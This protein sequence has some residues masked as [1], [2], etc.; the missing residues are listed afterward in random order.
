MFLGMRVLLL[1]GRKS[2]GR[3]P[4]PNPGLVLDHGQ[5]QGLDLGLDLDQEVVAG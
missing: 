5:D 2:Q 3:D 4:G 1:H